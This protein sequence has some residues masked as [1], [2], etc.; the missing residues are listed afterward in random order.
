MLRLN[1]Y[2]TT[3]IVLVIGPVALKFARRKRSGRRCNLYESD[4]YH[5]TTPER[6]AMLC[7]VIACSPRGS[8]L[9][10]RAAT[11]LTREEFDSVRS[12]DA[13]PDWDYDPHEGESCPFE[14]KP[15]DWGRLRGRLVAL[16]YSEP[17]LP[18]PDEEKH[19]FKEWEPPERR[20]WQWRG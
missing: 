7:P 10:T 17:A 16:D 9:I 12:A 20:W 6:R 3:R 18:V 15:S 2:G 1:N 11:P 8:V 14:W 4:L 13:F 19:L 5:R